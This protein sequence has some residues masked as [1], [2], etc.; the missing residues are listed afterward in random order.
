MKNKKQIKI[1]ASSV[2][3][4]I[5]DKKDKEIDGVVDNFIVYLKEKRLMTVLPEVIKEL[6]AL[7][8]EEQGIIKAQI[9]SKTDL[10]DRDI[11]AVA[12]I[13]KK[14]TGQEIITEQV[15]D[16][17]VLGGVVVK[18]NDKIIDMSL[19]RQLNNLSKQLSN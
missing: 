4:T 8:L 13:L 2:Y 1:L 9:S 16:E 15:K 7:Y 17:E 6:E 10:T 14:K 3:Q 12:D 11:K 19:K 5:K 18:Y